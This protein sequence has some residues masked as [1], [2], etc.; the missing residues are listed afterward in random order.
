MPYVKGAAPLCSRALAFAIPLL[1]ALHW[2]VIA[3][4]V[5]EVLMLAALRVA[6]LGAS[7]VLLLLWTGTGISRSELKWACALGGFL[8]VYLVAALCGT[9]IGR[10]LQD[11]VRVASAMFVGFG[12][13]RAFRHQP[14]AK[15][16]G[17]SCIFASLISCLLVLFTYWHYMGFRA[18]TYESLRVFKASALHGSGVALNPLAGAAFLFCLMGMCLLPSSW[19]L[20]SIAGFVLV[21]VG[22]LTGSRAP[23]ALLVVCGAVLL[24]IKWTRSRQLTHRVAAWGSLFLAV[25]TVAVALAWATPY[26]ISSAT[27]GRYDVW[28][29]GWNK[30]TESPLVG[31]GPDSWRDDLFS[32]LPGYYK[33]S[34]GLQKLK[35]GGYHSEYV[36][37]LAEGGSFCFF[38]ALVFLGM[39]LRDSLRTAFHPEAKRYRGEFIAF[40]CLFLCVRALIE[41]PGLFGYGQ[42]VTDYLA[43]LFVAVVASRM[44][45]LEPAYFNSPNFRTANA[46]SF[47]P[48]AA[49]PLGMP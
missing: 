23:I 44:S 34:A 28:T 17:R 6:L 10:G 36:T 42:D 24:F 29:V 4:H 1:L 25:V 15:A 12:A 19:A 3:L 49:L 41:I 40:T 14:T 45:L 39:L 48:V 33:E 38:P 7:L 13:A 11:W 8:L 35:A 30:F 27:E 47:P 5:K 22:G 31:Y 46:G 18:P 32:R 2:P 37:L 16:F 26:K 43:Y 9:N 20:R 21:V